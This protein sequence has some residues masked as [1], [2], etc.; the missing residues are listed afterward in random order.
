MTQDF[1]EPPKDVEELD[2]LLHRIDV[3][4]DDLA[5][6]SDEQREGLKEEL[7]QA[8]LTKWLGGYRVP[9]A[10]PEAGA[11]YRAIASGEKYPHLTDHIRQDLLI[12]FDEEHGEGG[13]V[14]WSVVERDDNPPAAGGPQP[15][16]RRK[17][18]R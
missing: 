5:A 6:L 9:V 8:W 7:G 10:L 4:H 11:L 1:P 18:S 14:H 17:D 3:G 12:R 2:A 15:A 16:L 13:P